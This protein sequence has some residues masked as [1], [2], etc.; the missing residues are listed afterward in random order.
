MEFVQ[1]PRQLNQIN[2][3]CFEVALSLQ[4]DGKKTMK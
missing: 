4:I 3:S 1:L 2:P